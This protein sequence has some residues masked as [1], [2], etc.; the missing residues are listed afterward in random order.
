M[1]SFWMRR[2]QSAAV[3]REGFFL[4]WDSRFFLD[5][6]CLRGRLGPNGRWSGGKVE[7]RPGGETFRR[8]GRI[9]RGLLENGSLVMLLKLM[10]GSSMDFLG[11]RRA[12]RSE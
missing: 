7:D 9:S 2:S 11:L 1:L 12:S 3:P 10:G 6:D 5:I 4:C 8:E